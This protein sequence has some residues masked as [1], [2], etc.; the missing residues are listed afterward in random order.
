VLYPLLALLFFLPAFESPAHALSLQEAFDLAE[1]AHGYDKYLELET[2]VV[3]TGGLLI[4]PI[5]SPISW[6]LEGDE[7]LDVCIVGNGAI[8]DLQGA[9]LCMSYC[10]NRLDI[11]DC[12][13]L[14]GNIRYR[15]INT[16]DYVVLPEGSVR[17]VTFYGPHDYGVRLQGAG[18]GITLERNL[19]VNAVDTG[20]DFIYT[21][22]TSHDCLP[23]GTNICFSIQFGFY[24]IPVIHENWSYHTDPETNADMLAH[25]SLLC[26]YG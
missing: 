26:E 9:Q 12:I 25:F 7:G 6:R 23:T 11:E 24:G 2:G 15:G 13:I 10:N 14:N 16:S 8:L 20:W 3:Y 21:H 22:G 19:L 4:G 17:Y 1:P 18:G 5:Y